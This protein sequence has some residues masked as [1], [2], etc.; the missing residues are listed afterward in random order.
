M[1]EELKNEKVQNE[2]SEG[3]AEVSNKA[4]EGK[5]EFA[6]RGNKR[7][8][9]APV[10]KREESPYEDRVVKVKRISKTV[11]GGRR[12]RFSALIVCGD[13]KGTYGFGTGKSAEVPEAIKKASDRAKTNLMKLPMVEGDTIPHTVVGHFGATQVFLKP[14]KE[15]TGIIAGGA[16]RVI[17]EL[18]GIRNIYSKVYGRRTPINAIRAVIDGLSQL[19]SKKN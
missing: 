5:K 10:R 15:G 4:N 17:L 1:S 19:K 8:A 6:R 14:A 9:Q 13:K 2:V 11:K 7:S 16:V 18:A 3:N 12:M